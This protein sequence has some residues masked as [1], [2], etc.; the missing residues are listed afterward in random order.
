MVTANFDLGG[1]TIKR[2]ELNIHDNWKPGINLQVTLQTMSQFSSLCVYIY[3][4]IYKIYI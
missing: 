4:Y 2:Q 1:G 3:I